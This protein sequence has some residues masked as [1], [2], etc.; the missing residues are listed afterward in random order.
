MQEDGEDKRVESKQSSLYRHNDSKQHD[1]SKAN[2]HN[3]AEAGDANWLPQNE[4]IIRLLKPL[5]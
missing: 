5:A 2:Y 3:I 1:R 4:C